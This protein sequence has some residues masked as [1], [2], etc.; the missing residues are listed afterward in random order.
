MI[1]EAYIPTFALEELLATKLRA[2]YQRRKGRDLFDLW[3]GLTEGKAS[4]TKI[5]DIFRHYMAHAGQSVVR[6]AFVENL[7]LKRTHPGFS[8]DMDALL[9]LDT[10]YNFQAGFNLIEKEIV[11]CM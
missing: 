1:Q 4:S 2:L 5:V 11:A 10:S 9:P 8:A 6:A 7:A 3:L